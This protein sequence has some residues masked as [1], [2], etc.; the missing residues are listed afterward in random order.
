MALTQINPVYSYDCKG[1]AVIPMCPTL[2]IILAV[3]S[4]PLKV[5]LCV[6]IL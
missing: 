4:S 1:D 5:A 6:C 3:G 2:P